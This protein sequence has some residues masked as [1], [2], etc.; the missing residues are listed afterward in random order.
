MES[1]GYFRARSHELAW[2]IS[3]YFVQFYPAA[4][5]RGFCTTPHAG[6]FARAG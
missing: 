4:C 3:G 6:T 5:G 1:L 2:M